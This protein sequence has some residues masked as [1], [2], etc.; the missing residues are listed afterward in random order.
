MNKERKPQPFDRQPGEGSRAWEA[1]QTYRDSGPERSVRGVA[2]KLN[3]SSTI[4]GRWS[5]RWS[6]VERVKAWELD[7]AERLRVSEQDAMKKNAHLWAKR[8]LEFKEREYTI[9]N[10]LLAKAEEILSHS[11]RR[12]G[13]KAPARFSLND[14]SRM[15]AVGSELIRRATG[16]ATDKTEIT[17]PDNAP[18]SAG[19]VILFLPDNGR[20]KAKTE[21]A[22]A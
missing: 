1:F 13:N 19:Q 20:D 16:L 4:I 15:A 8:Q 21:E 10:K 2:R 17:G 14:A 12:Q 9:G 5:G 6:W 7:Q 22:Q 18:I 11:T 3:K